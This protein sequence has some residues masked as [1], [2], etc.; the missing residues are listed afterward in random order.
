MVTVAAISI[1]GAFGSSVLREKGKV[2][3]KVSSLHDLMRVE[4]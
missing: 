2:G 4:G 3:G 1:S